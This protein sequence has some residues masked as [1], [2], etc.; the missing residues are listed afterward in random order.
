MQHTDGLRHGVRLAILIEALGEGLFR[1][2]RG[3]ND[4]VGGL[5]LGLAL[6]EGQE[7]RHFGLGD[8]ERR[9]IVRP[10]D[11]YYVIRYAHADDEGIKG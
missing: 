5:A 3:I 9:K 4:G 8:E 11:V 1:G 10:I 6:E 7:R 2:G